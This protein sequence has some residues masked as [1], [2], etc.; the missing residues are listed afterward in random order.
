MSRYRQSRASPFDI[1]SQR[2]S[3]IVG[4]SG[5]GKTALLNLIGCIDKPTQG[6]IFVGGQDVGTLDGK[7]STKQ[8]GGDLRK[9]LSHQARSYP[10]KSAGFRRPNRIAPIPAASTRAAPRTPTHTRQARFVCP[11]RM[12]NARSDKQQA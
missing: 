12:I 11:A 9:R 5:S 1:P 6:T 2:F 7:L 3:M 4:P 10:G 8:W